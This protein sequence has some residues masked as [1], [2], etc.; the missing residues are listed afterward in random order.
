MKKFL[1]LLILISLIS[2]SPRASNV[3][4]T[5]I[6]PDRHVQLDDIWKVTFSGGFSYTLKILNTKSQ[7]YTADADGHAGFV[8]TESPLLEITT[9]PNRNIEDNYPS[10]P[11]VFIKEKSVSFCVVQEPSGKIFYSGK[12][13]F[14]KPDDLVKLFKSELPLPEICKMQKV[15]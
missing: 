11:D 9:F 4:S 13:F 10:Y 8:T 14:G 5:M 6:D 1:F 2:C 7:P 3:Q 12:G 15:N